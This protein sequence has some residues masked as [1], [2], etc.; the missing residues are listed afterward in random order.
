MEVRTIGLRMVGML[1]GPVLCTMDEL[2]SL[3]W[4]DMIEVWPRP[5]W[6]H[7]P[8]EHLV[9]S[10]WENLVGDRGVEPI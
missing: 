1:S 10:A 2:E 7:A 9:T 8:V 6:T 5:R 4:S 3:P